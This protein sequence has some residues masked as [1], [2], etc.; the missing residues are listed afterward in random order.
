MDDA[1]SIAFLSYA[2]G[3]LAMS[4]HRSE[5][6]RVA[7]PPTVGERIKLFWTRRAEDASN[8]RAM[9]FEM[10]RQLSPRDQFR[11]ILALCNSISVESLNRNVA[12]LRQMLLSQYGQMFRDHGLLTLP[13]RP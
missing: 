7:L 3:V 4:V 6:A 5:I 12:T 13:S 2:A 8:M 9:W 11:V 1:I 10:L